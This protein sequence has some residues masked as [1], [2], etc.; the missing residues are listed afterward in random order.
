MPDDYSADIHTDGSVAV[1]GSAATGEIETARDFDWFA[2]ELVAGRTYVIDVEGDDTG[3]GTLRNTVLRGLYDAHGDLIA[4]T[5]DKDGGIGKNAQLTFTATETETHYIEARG[6]RS[7]TGTYTVEVTDVT[8]DLDDNR[9]PVFAEESYEF[10]LAENVDGSTNR[11]SLGTVAAADPDND[12][13]EYRIAA[14]NALGLFEIDARTGELFYAGIGMDFS[15]YGVTRFDLTVRASDGALS[16]DTAVS[17]NV[18]DEPEPTHV[19]PPV[20]AQQQQTTTQPELTYSEPP[21]PAQQQQYS[22]TSV[23][24][25]SGTDFPADSATNGVVVVGESAT[26][27]IGQAN[28]RDWFAVDLQANK[29]YR[30]DLEGSSTGEGTLVDPY[31]RGVYD[32]DGDLIPGTGDDEGGRGHNSRVFFTASDDATYYVAA[33]AYGSHTGTYKLSVAKVAK[34]DFAA[35]TETTGEVDVNDSTTGQIELPGDRD[36]LGVELEKGKLYEIELKRPDSGDDLLS[37]PSLEGVYDEDENLIHGGSLNGLAY[38]EP[39]EDVTYYVE[40]GGNRGSTGKYELSVTQ[41]QDDFLD[42]SQTTGKVQVEGSTIGEREYYRDEDW[43]AVDLEMGRTYRINLEG[44]KAGGG[45]LKDP[46]LYG[47]EGPVYSHSEIDA[48]NE[49]G[50]RTRSQ[51]FVTATEDATCYIKVGSS[52]FWNY[53][54]GTYT[55]RVTDVTDALR[56]D[57]AAGIETTGQ[58]AVGGSERGE[59]E[60][61]YDRD[62]FEVILEAGVTYRIELKGSEVT[63]RDGTLEDPYLYGVHDENGKR[64]PGTA[65]NDGGVG[66]NSSMHFKASEDG[67][68]YIA[69]GGYNYYTPG[70]GTYTLSV[71]RLA[72]DDFPAGTETTGTV[73]VDGSATGE[74]ETQRDRDWFA[75]ALEKDKTYQIDLEGAESGAGTLLNPYLHGIYDS[76]D[77]DLLPGTSDDNGGVGAFNSRVFFTATENATYYVS[78]GASYQGT[79]TYRLSV[80]QVAEDDF[81]AGTGTTGTVDVDGSATGTI[82]QPDDRDWFAV[83][84]AADKTYQI[85]LKGSLTGDGTLF[86]PYLD[87]I[88]DDPGGTFIAGTSDDDGGVLR[89]SQIVFT[90]TQA[91]T[92]YVAAGSSHDLTGTYTLSVEEVV[93]GM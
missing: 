28:D 23:S 60:N 73:D 62:W 14:G 34:D 5:R 78:A 53:K 64:I 75:V 70:T 86:D 21:V 40:V 52:W 49:S 4:D 72:G 92:H 69:A 85:D 20:P 65:D 36:W 12:A 17:V 91:G 26:G 90:A 87:G 83:T 35:G 71:T 66:G 15:A 74:L 84:L 67:T 46:R 48:G 54:V 41:I 44:S 89:N 50:A 30:I 11:V 2:V 8:P 38:L 31:L 9:P 18:T 7:Q 29:T 37:D 33:G 57:Y 82:E 51:Q 19:E 27:E 1:G 80:T 32:K 56:D 59:V 63:I 6:K 42:N 93:D 79:G 16:A 24:E 58:V 76:P 13:V 77:G 55:V 3:A 61:A 25:P 39:T 68:H 43:F 81:S 10:S 22:T 47:I 45:T 88:Y